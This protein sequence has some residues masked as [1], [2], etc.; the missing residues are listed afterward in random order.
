MPAK[1]ELNGEGTD[2]ISKQFDTYDVAAM[3][4]EQI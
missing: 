4:V 1:L 2:V 3:V